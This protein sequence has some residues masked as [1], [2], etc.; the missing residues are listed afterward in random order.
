MTDSSAA[1]KRFLV[2]WD[3]FHR[4]CKALAWRL[5]DKSAQWKGI[6]AITRGGMIPAGIVARELEIKLVETVGI[7]SYDDK[8]RG[9]AKVIKGIDAKLVGDGDGWLVIDDL[10]DSGNTAKM[11]RQM[12]PKAHIATVYAKPSGEPLADTYV[13]WVSQDTWIYFPWDIDI[14]PM[15]PIATVR[16]QS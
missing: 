12:L 8:T 6:I 11:L 15:D 4:D 2:S 7:S 14:Q 5:V 9:A 3:Q 13:T 1:P 10:V 16:K